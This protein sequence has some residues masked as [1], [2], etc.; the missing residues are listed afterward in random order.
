V[1]YVRPFSLVGDGLVL[2]QDLQ[3]A[4]E[5]HE[6]GVDVGGLLQVRTPEE[7]KGSAQRLN[8]S[9]CERSVA[10]WSLVRP[11]RSAPARSHK[12][13][14]LQTSRLFCSEVDDVCVCVCVCVCMYVFVSVYACL[15][16][17]INARG[18]ADLGEK[19]DGED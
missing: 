5:D 4:P 1:S 8:S 12:D 19:L 18:E 16:L 7:W 13:S 6:R 15:C 10:Y 11:V 9:M 2:S 17:C 3:A 14:R